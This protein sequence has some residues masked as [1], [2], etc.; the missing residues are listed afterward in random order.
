MISL[1]LPLILVV[2]AYLYAT[3]YEDG[4]GLPRAVS[5]DG[6]DGPQIMA[7]ESRDE[8]KLTRQRELISELAK[9]HVGASITGRS[10]EDLSVLQQILDLRML[11]RDNL[12]EYQSMGVALGDVM[13]AQLGLD[14]VVVEDSHGRSRALRYRSTKNLI[15][16]VTMLSRRVEKEE[17]FTVRELYDL[18]E[19]RVMEFSATPYEV[20]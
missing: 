1:G 2:V 19:E 20:N 18:G 13:A 6:S 3:S 10:L 5:L 16:P 4:G 12:F 17:R 15:F 11:G 9:R 14:W 7:L 8:R